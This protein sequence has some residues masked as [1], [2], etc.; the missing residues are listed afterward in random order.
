M[1]KLILNEIKNKSVE[2]IIYTSV[3]CD[4]V[5][6]GHINLFRKAKSLGDILIVGV[7]SDQGVKNY[8]RNPIIPFEQRLEVVSSIKYVDY[9]IRQQARSGTANMKILG[10]VSCLIRGDDDEISDEVEYIK[11]IGGE[12]IKILYTKGVSSSKIISKINL[13]NN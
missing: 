6:I 3:V 7:I 11:S 8:K 12:F 9:A 4:L 10:N 5:H 13:R 1:N 2:K